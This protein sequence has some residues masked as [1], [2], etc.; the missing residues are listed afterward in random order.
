M[1]KTKNIKNI[2]LICPKNLH[3]TIQATAVL[4]NLDQNTPED[5][6]GDINVTVIAPALMGDVLASYRQVSQ[7]HLVSSKQS[8]K[9]SL[10]LFAHLLGR[11]WAKI[12]DL[13]NSFMPHFLWASQ[14]LTYKAQSGR[15][16]V[17]A[18]SALLGLDEVVVPEILPPETLRKKICSELNV[19]HPLLVMGPASALPK[20]C[21]ASKNFAQL[22]WMLA[23][24]NG[25]L[26]NAKIIFVISP[27][28]E[29]R[30][31]EISKALPP[32]Q[33]FHYV[34]KQMIETAALLAEASLCVA[35]ES[36]LSHLAAATGTATV[37]LA[38][39][40]HEGGP[41]GANC[42]TLIPN[43][44]ENPFDDTDLSVD[45]V[46]DETKKILKS[47]SE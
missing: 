19:A 24:P 2:L 15:H 4:K 33:F 11:R 22:A 14:R 8:I 41:W 20:D 30:L 12:I 34:A 40:K 47:E 35:N 6:S 43:F 39:G 46:Y 3:G 9:D 1:A 32:G 27:G 17:E 18:V 10:F 37:S 42:K 13:R 36:W 21:W 38:L 45:L 16:P 29:A 7:L 23:N 25:P 26:A 31:S 44:A 5:I 28:E